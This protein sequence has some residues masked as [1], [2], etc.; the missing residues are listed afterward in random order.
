MSQNQSS[1]RVYSLKDVPMVY[2]RKYGDELDYYNMLEMADHVM[3]QAGTIAPK[4]FLFKA[5]I[6]DFKL[7]LPCNVYSIEYVCDAKPVSWFGASII[8]PETNALINYRVDQS[9][10]GGIYNEDAT[11][12][13]N[14]G[15]PT[16]AGL[17]E[18]N[19]SVF[20]MPLG[21]MI[22]FQNDNNCCLSFNIKERDVMVLYHGRILDADQATMVPD[23]TIAAIAAYCNLYE[24]T[25]RFNRNQASPAHVQ[26][27]QDEYNRLVSQAR[28]PDGLGINEMND[29]LDVASSMNRKRYNRQ[30]R[31]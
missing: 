7:E 21:R 8:G 19:R 31:F 17:Y 3:K 13:D 1:A 26:L 2:R 25:K 24:V 18:V 30:H 27:A 4:L 23:T 15:V 22:N 14:L 29:A 5:K 11:D 9:R 16:T 28:V 20:E 12:Q 10:T 6:E